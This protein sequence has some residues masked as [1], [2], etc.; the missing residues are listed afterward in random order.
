MCHSDSL[1]SICQSFNTLKKRLRFFFQFQS[2]GRA[3]GSADRPVVLCFPRRA[4]WWHSIVCQQQGPLRRGAAPFMS[5]Q[6]IYKDLICLEIKPVSLHTGKLTCLF[7]WLGGRR[8]K[9]FLYFVLPPLVL[10][11]A[12]LFMDSRWDSLV[13]LC[14]DVMFGGDRTAAA[15]VHP[16]EE[17]TIV[18]VS[19][20]VCFQAR[21]R[22]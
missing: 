7:L 22:V 21:W 20:A 16:P 14:R 3:P 2:I 18:R 10:M 13:D 4:V 9:V 8:L 12:P 6:D 1:W 17:A 11:T 15:G 5:T 19:S